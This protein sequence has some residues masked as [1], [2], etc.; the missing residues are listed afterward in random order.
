MKDI[1]LQYGWE[2]MGK[3]KMTGMLSFKK[4]N[5]RLNIYTT[6]GTVTFQNAHLNYDKATSY[7]E[8]TEEQL[9]ALLSPAKN[10]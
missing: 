8:V 10:N 6:T 3:Q 2:D 1:P 4:D 5:M 7:R 9:H